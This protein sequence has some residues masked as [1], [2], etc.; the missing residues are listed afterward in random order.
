M[1]AQ[2]LGA[3]LVLSARSGRGGGTPPGSSQAGEVG[4]AAGTAGA[5]GGA[6]VLSTGGRASSPDGGGSPH[7]TSTSFTLSSATGGSR[8]P[9]TVGLVFK[10]GDVPLDFGLDLQT[11][12]VEVKRRWNDGSVKHAMISGHVDLVPRTKDGSID[13]KAQRN[14]TDAESR[15]MKSSDGYV[16]AYNCQAVVDEE[17]QIIV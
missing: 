1:R 9:F 4:R 16:Q 2:L 5:G 11:A 15:I 12:Q 10:K 3:A 14:F 7:A 13:P 8:L 17:H 6:V